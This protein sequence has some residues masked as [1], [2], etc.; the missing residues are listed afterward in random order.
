MTSAKEVSF[1]TVSN[2]V[3]EFTISF[4]GSFTVGVAIGVL[5]SLVRFPCVLF[6]LVLACMN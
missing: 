2:I 1:I 5:S 4:A 3:L 6:L